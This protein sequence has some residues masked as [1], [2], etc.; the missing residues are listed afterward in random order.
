M[1]RLL[2]LALVALVAVAAPAA[3]VDAGTWMLKVGAHDV[4]PK[5]DNGTLADGA[6]AI[7]VDSS[8]RPTIM[9]EYFPAKNVGIE[10]L[11]AWPFEHDVN[12][13]GALVGT[14]Q[15]LP[16]TLSLQYHFDR[17]GKVVPYIGA[18][19]NYTFFFSEET[20]GPIK[21]TDLQLGSS[22]GLAGHVGIDFM[23]A[24]AWSW[25]IDARWIDIDS[26]V[27]VNGTKLGTVAIDPW[28]YGAYVQYR[29]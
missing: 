21:G 16:P 24:G 27:R 4:D 22:F 18:G 19:L 13:N 11:A 12:A 25:G 20:T 10:L 26:D 17:G 7:E 23:G 28:A 1:K 3:A 5:S 2:S 9:F 8:I 15:H 29:F 14:V 6:L